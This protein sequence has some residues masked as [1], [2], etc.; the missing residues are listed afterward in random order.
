MEQPAHRQRLT[1]GM[2]L[3]RHRHVGAYAALVLSGGYEEA[4]DAG[5]RRVQPGDVVLHGPFEAHLDRS[6]ERGAEVL[7]LALPEGVTP[8]GFGRLEDADV[9]AR[10]AERDPAEAARLLIALTRQTAP[11]PADWP[12][13]LAAALSG[14]SPLRLEAW[15]RSQGLTP[16]TVS[17]G[18]HRVFGVSPSRFGLEARARRAWAAVRATPETL[19]AIAHEAGFADQAHMTRTV[20]ALT[21]RPP[22]A[23]RSLAA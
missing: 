17:R 22:G 13:R 10:L 6:G 9:V 20:T 21:G 8:G 19:A 18:F 1:P 7:N 2:R 5:R 11:S 4:G 15:A 16:E 3:A 12:D 23:W 14:S